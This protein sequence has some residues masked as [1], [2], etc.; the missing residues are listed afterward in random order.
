MS[1]S[2]RCQAPVPS[3]KGQSLWTSSTNSRLLAPLAGKVADPAIE[4]FPAVQVHA[5]GREDCDR[6]RCRRRI[7]TQP[8]DNGEAVDVRHKQVQNHQAWSL[9]LCECD[10]FQSTGRVETR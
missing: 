10:P 2:L 9:S 3:R 5:S 1:Y 7:D 4:A 8:F 6:D